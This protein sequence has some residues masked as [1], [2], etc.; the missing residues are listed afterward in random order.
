MWFIIIINNIYYNNKMSK[1]IHLVL[2]DKFFGGL[3][4]L[5]KL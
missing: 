5:K 2:S 1:I 3:L 4:S